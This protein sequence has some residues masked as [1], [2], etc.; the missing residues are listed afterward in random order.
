M[1]EVK[2]DQIILKYDWGFLQQPL[3][4]DNVPAGTFLGGGAC[5]DLRLQVDVYG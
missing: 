5:N 4:G 3:C 2:S 1:D